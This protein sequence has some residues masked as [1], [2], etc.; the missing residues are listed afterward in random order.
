MD[1]MNKMTPEQALQLIGQATEPANI[2]RLT[3]TDYVNIN[4][5]LVVLD[6][7]LKELSEF[8]K[9]KY[10]PDAPAA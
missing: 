4:A 1:P 7:A 9:P 8:K 6:A 2:A 10:V 3:R 5:A